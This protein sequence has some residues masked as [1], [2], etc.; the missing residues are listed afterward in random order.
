M[1]VQPRPDPQAAALEKDGMSGHRFS[2]EEECAGPVLSAGC[3]CFSPLLCVT[4]LGSSDQEEVVTREITGSGTDWKYLTLSHKCSQE[5]L[6]CCPSLPGRLTENT[7]ER[8][9]LRVCLCL[10]VFLM[11]LHCSNNNM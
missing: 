10:F 6:D 8:V 11:M 2:C 9:T 5:L 3:R 7:G 1:G 4:D